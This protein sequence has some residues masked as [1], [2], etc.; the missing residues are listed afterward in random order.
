MPYP[1]KQIISGKL[2][3]SKCN[4]LLPLDEFGK[5]KYNSTGYS[6]CCKACR[7]SIYD[8]KR[9]AISNIGLIGHHKHTCIQCNKDFTNKS[10]RGYFCS[11][12]CR[13]RNWYENNEQN[14]KEPNKLNERW[15]LKNETRTM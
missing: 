8:N 1:K 7:K 3:C 13:K 14:V 5:S 11:D 2:K 9:Y 10:N 12:K 6:S 4:Y 15:L